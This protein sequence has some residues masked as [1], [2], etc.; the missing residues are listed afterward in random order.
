ML[1]AWSADTSPF[2]ASTALEKRKQLTTSL[3]F[4]S[5][6]VSEGHALQLRWRGL[7]L[8]GTKLALLRQLMPVVCFVVV[9]GALPVL[10]GTSPGC[11][12]NG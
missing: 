7:E 1:P 11:Q 6:S 9:R 5:G 3:G 8:L 2:D 4:S 10:T 12:D